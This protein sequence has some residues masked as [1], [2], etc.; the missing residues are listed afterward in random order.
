MM[1]ALLQ[2]VRFGLRLLARDRSF[3]ITALLT[4]AV[5]IGANAAMFSVVRSVLLKPL[6]FPGSDR[7]VLLYNSYPKAGAPRVGAAVPDFFD[8]LAGV[9]ALS[10]QALFR[11]ES[12]AF[13]EAEGAERLITIRATPSFFKVVRIGAARGRVFDDADGQAGQNQKVLLSY[14]FWQRK[15]GGRD[16]VIGQK[17]RLNGQPFDVVGVLPPEFSFLQNDVDAFTPAAFAPEEKGD[18]RRHSNNWQ[19]VGRMADG[20]TVARVQE[21][22]DAVNRRNDERLPEFRQI[23]KDAN[24]RTV[25][26]RLQDDLVRDIRSALYLLWGGVLFVLVIG[27]VNLANLTMVRS[28]GR[29]RE[30]ATR[31]AIGGELGR[32]GRQLLTETTV[33]SI[34][35][36]AAGVLLAWWGTRSVAALN[37]DQL[38]RGYEIALDTAGLAFASVLT[39]G[40][41]LVLG[42]APALKLRS[43][44]LSTALREESRGGSSGRVAQQVRRMLAMAQVSIALV[45]LIGAGLL[46]ASFLA[47]LRLDLGFTPDSVYTASVNLPGAAYA[48]APARVA[49]AARA[50][51]RLRAI[52]GVTR[53]GATTGLPFGGSQ[54]TN[55]ILAEGHVMQ[56]G[57]SLIAPLQVLA[58]EDYFETMKIPIVRG[59]PFTSSDTLDAPRVAIIDEQLAEKF[60]PGQDPIGRRLYRPSDLKDVTKITPQTIFMTV[61]GVV[62]NV[63][64]ADPRS[65]FT[66]VGTY[67]FP[68]AATAPGGMTFALQL[69]GPSATIGIDIKRAVAAVDVSLPVFRVQPM[70][71]WIDRALVGRRAPMWIAAA[72]SLVALFLAGIGIYGVLAYG[73]SARRRELGVRMALGGSTGSVFRLVL[74]D[75]LTIVGVGVAG[76]LVGSYFLGRA[77]E[78]LLFGV[79]PLNPGVIGAVTLILAAVALLATGIPA[80]RASRINP[81]LVLSK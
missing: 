77:M 64:V 38:P 55:V 41:G 78:S 69:N 32:L 67:Y 50:L 8:R 9:P 81:V 33:L 14:G 31:H 17:I 40:V 68:I 34:A 25:T 79:A 75:G 61:V 45:L 39:I 51:E 28:A 7:V 57:E 54:N 11:R 27:C 19:M 62:K 42:V 29:A 37:L 20:A 43:I 49:F 48:D 30:M 46:L 23:L 80:F 3:T 16:N 44:N 47:V 13:G 10:D 12:M 2:D 53:A 52:P 72:F 36:G 4:L 59:R 21:Q 60:W 71:E 5:C 35:G 6:P 56:P 73:V 24:F 70:Q 15:F 26:V 1:A 65:E 74:R 63:V 18:D 58:S 76:G 66:P 22:V